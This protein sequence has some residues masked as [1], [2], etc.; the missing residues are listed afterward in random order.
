MDYDSLEHASDAELENLVVWLNKGSK[1]GRF[2]VTT[3]KNAFGFS[4]KKI[5]DKNTFKTYTY[6]QAV[7]LLEQMG[8]EAATKN[9]TIKKYVNG[10]RVNH[11][12]EEFDEEA[13]EDDLNH[14]GVLGMKWGQH[15]FGKDKTKTWSN[16]PKY[17]KEENKTRKDLVRGVT[18]AQRNLKDRRKL[19]KT[20]E[21]NLV[22]AKKENKAARQMVVLPWNKSKKREIVAETERFVQE[23]MKDL[24]IPTADM[25]RAKSYVK[26][27]TKALQD[28]AEQMNSKYG[29][30]NIKQLK[31]KDS[32]TRYEDGYGYVDKFVKT[33]VNMANFPVICNWISANYVTAWED[34]DREDLLKKRSEQRLTNSY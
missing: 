1:N 3:V 27:Q 33:G 26:K 32:I 25:A 7:K 11:S 17:T 30:E 21:M 4:S 6:R 12:D 5:L 13:S 9:G 15:L 18:A 2:Q 16:R 28:F 23:A 29:A 31:Y 10:K 34:T 14:Y 24:E 22:R 19:A 8:V 20:A